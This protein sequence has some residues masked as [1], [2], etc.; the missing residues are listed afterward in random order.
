MIGGYVLTCL[1]VMKIIFISPI[2]VKYSISDKI[3]RHVLKKNVKSYEE[4]SWLESR[5]DEIVPVL[6]N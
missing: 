4:Y 1:Q 2:K 3:A 5:S 6:Q